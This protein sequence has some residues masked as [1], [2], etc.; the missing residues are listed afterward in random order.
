M[1]EFGPTRLV[2]LRQHLTPS[3]ASN[4]ALGA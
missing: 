4:A 3:D 2:S 1:D